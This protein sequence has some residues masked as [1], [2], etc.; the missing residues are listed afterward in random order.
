MKQ[1]NHK[2]LLLVIAMISLLV[3]QLLFLVGCA[4][5]K[6]DWEKAQRLN[7]IE[8]YEEFLQKHPD[9]EFAYEAKHKIEELAWERAK[10]Q[11]TIEAYEEFLQKHPFSIFALDAKERIANLERFK[12][13]F[14]A[15]KTSFQLE[16]LLG[17]YPEQGDKIIP[18]LE[19][20]IIEEII[21]KGVK[22]R[23]VIK[24]ITP[25]IDDSPYSFT[26][27]STKKGQILRTEFPGD[28][29]PMFLSPHPALGIMLKPVIMF[30]P[31]SIHRFVGKVNL[32]IDGQIYSF[33]GEGDKLHRLTFGII[34][35][36]G[37]VYL[38]GKGRVIL[39]NGKEVKL[40]Y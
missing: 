14:E 25:A 29:I 37:Y 32:E 23:F 12:K 6:K 16:Q 22:N 13:I 15:A 21:A 3:G 11:N 27:E 30:T 24:K 34:K 8:A 1:N 33:I 39:K 28:K 40:G 19:H 26:I 20:M 5:P 31:G 36:I 35:N 7:T 38:R 17:K 10:E 4:T 2:S 9:S 18:K